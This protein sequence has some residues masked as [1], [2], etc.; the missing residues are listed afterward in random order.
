M[1]CTNCGHELE[2]GSGF[3]ENCGTIM[4]LDDDYNPF[5]SNNEESVYINEN[6]GT[7][8]ELEADDTEQIVLSEEVP[9]D[10]AISGESYADFEPEAETAESQTNEEAEAVFAE[11]NEADAE[12]EAEAETTAESEEDATSEPKAEAESDSEQETE[13]EPEA[14]NPFDAAEEDYKEPSEDEEE[15]GDDDA[16]MYVTAK[17]TKK[18]TLAIIAL[19]G[20]LV[21]VVAGGVNVIK[22]NFI[23]QPTNSVNAETSVTSGEE[24]EESTNK[25][26]DATTQP[27]EE[28]SDEETTEKESEEQT[29]EK[30]EETASKT[31]VKSGTETSKQTEKATTNASKV[32][33]SSKPVTTTKAPTTTKRPTTTK[34]PVTTKKPTTT[35]A[36]STTKKP[37]TTKTPAITKPTT[38]APVTSKD[39]HGFNFATVQKPNKYFSSPSKVYVNTNALA[40][41]SKPTTKSENIVYL[42]LGTSCTA[43]ASQDGFLYVRS[44][45][46]GV[47]GWVSKT[48]TSNS[49]PVSQNSIIV[50]NLVEPDKEFETK[51]TKYVIPAD[52]LRLRKGPGEDYG[53]ILRLDKGFPVKVI[54]YSTSDSNWYYVK[55]TTHGIYGWVSR[56]YL[57]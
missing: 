50:P 46:Y 55:D 6:P 48:Y 15:V 25:Q 43:Y 41:R 8:R 22:N 20:V 5:E 33:S 9:D 51:T 23:A 34:A 53:I 57:K 17:K 28:N 7:A 56:W 49:R 21:A 26:V 32:P 42:P 54:G 37:S 36:P 14:D 29:T 38:N 40:L 52:G 47:Y 35:K 39:P 18:G 3:C 19:V 44:D 2:P 27:T 31:T 24:T 4:S 1:K 16:D 12:A 13:A 45:R 10:E 11:E 30:E